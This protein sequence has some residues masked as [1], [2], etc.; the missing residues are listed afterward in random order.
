MMTDTEA[1][2]ILRAQGYVASTP[3]DHTG[4]VRVWLH[5]SDEAID[6]QIGKELRELAEGKLSF[7]DIRAWREDESLARRD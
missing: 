3:D 2:D 4:R 5:G 1:L 6:V 7:D